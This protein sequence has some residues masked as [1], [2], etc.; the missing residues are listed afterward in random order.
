MNQFPRI[1]TVFGAGLA[2]VACETTDPAA[3]PDSSLE[4]SAA[5][6]VAFDGASYELAAADFL[7]NPFPCLR[8]YAEPDDRVETAVEADFDSPLPRSA[9]GDDVDFFTMA[10]EAGQVADVV[11][12]FNRAEGDIEVIVTAPDGKFLGSSEIRGDRAEVSFVAEEA[13]D[14][15]IVVVLT[16]DRGGA[17]GTTY[18]I[19]VRDPMA[20]CSPDG[21]EPNDGLDTS[22][23]LAGEAIEQTAC[24]ADEDWFTFSAAEGDRIVLN[25]D[26]EATDGDVDFAVYAPDGSFA[27]GVFGNDSY[28]SFDTVAEQTGQYRALVYLAEGSQAGVAY[29]VYLTVDGGGADGQQ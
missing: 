25:V 8:D 20:E 1:L 26:S 3:T 11:A 2:L 10:L 14:H 17:D 27:G 7:N 5:A 22:S 16:G 15:R 29:D 9:C 24:S 28:A 23:E 18:S 4:T 12:R 13:G 6:T 21:S 19:R